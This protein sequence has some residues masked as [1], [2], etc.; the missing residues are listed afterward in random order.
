MTRTTTGNRTQRLAWGAALGLNA[1]L[2][3]PFL[4]WDDLRRSDLS[5]VPKSAEEVEAEKKRREGL[6]KKP[7][8]EL[9]KEKVEEAAKLIEQRKRE[10]IRKKVEELERLHEEIEEFKDEQLEVLAERDPEKELVEQLADAVREQADELARKAED[11]EQQDR[12]DQARQLREQAQRLRDQAAQLPK[13]PE[14]GQPQPQQPSPE[15]TAETAKKVA[16]MATA[17]A[18]TSKQYEQKQPSPQA[19]DVARQAQRLAERAQGLAN[20][21]AKAALAGLSEQQP[22][23]SGDLEQ[24]SAAE[25]YERARELEERIA[26]QFAD[27]KAAELALLQDT[28]FQQALNAVATPRTTAADLGDSLSQTPQ[29]RE[30]LAQFGEALDKALANAARAAA[31]AQNLL[32]Q[33]QDRQ[34]VRAG[35]ERSLNQSAA[36]QAAAMAASFNQASTQGDN[37][38]GMMVDLTGMMSQAYG[39]SSGGSDSGIRADSNRQ[40]GGAGMAAGVRTAQINLDSGRIIAQ[41]LPGRKFSPASARKGWL[42]IDSWYIVGPWENRGTIDFN[43][44]HP[45]ETHIDYD[46]IYIGKGGREL[47]W[48]YLQSNVMRINPHDE[49]SNTTYYGSTE[50]HFEQETDML[51]AVASDDAAKV[52]VNGI[53]VW[54]DVGL[55]SWQLDEGFRKVRFKKG[56]NELLVR[57]EN[58]PGPCYYSLLL[59]PAD[60][61]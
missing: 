15:Q 36:Q 34:Q 2:L 22:P 37:Q 44:R 56:F 20:S 3:V 43:V 14:P 19:T 54:Q 13:L 8:P 51:L 61:K 5:V 16:E 12:N 47:K 45:P 60:A 9:A 35:G 1:V 27:A 33:A 29:N 4:I 31:N 41:A 24:L 26:K 48:R 18:A 49:Q 17:I 38:R 57:L 55:S 46:A 39:G 59:C 42:F 25:L 32:G 40:G 30:Q 6:A 7:K 23:A 58:G 10:Q 50:V 11:L 52:W 53:V 28:G 21:D